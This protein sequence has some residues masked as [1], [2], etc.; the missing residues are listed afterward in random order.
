MLKLDEFNSGHGGLD[1]YIALLSQGSFN[2]NQ[3][4][5]SNILTKLQ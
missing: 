1:V 3:S 2:Q 5:I 4:N